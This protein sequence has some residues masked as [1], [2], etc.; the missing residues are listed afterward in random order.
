MVVQK[1][2]DNISSDNSHNQ[3]RAGKAETEDK[4]A[5]QKLVSKTKDL[6]KLKREFKVLQQ[7]YNNVSNCLNIS[8]NEL[9]TLKPDHAKLLKKVEDS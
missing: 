6:D 5:K 3:L 8:D 9:K 7:S 1:A 4:E 2:L